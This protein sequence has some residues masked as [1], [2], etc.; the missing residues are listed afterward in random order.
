MGYLMSLVYDRVMRGVE[1]AGLRAWRRAL[2]AQA[3]G[4]V[5]EVGAGTG[6]NLGLY[7]EAVDELVASEPDRWMVKRLE[8]A[9]AQVSRPRVTVAQASLE[10][11]PFED[12]AFDTVVCTL[13]LCSVPELA[14]AVGEIK[15]VLRPGGRLLFLEHVA[16]R[17][18]P[19]RLRWQRRVEPVWRRVA[20]G[21]CLTRRTE[22][23]LRSA[24]FSIEAIE[25]E[26]MRKVF[27]L[28]RP[29][30]RGVAVKPEAQP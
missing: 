19:T 15:R 4:R 26:S 25:R 2:L 1:E 27:A 20:G 18:R 11:L 16:A 9:A 21:C 14:E 10:G 6:V 30:I 3:S 24:G 13:V 7:P 22:E 29:S 8:R 23:A 28:A 5:L 17:D 12:G